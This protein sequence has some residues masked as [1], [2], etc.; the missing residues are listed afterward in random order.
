M[1]STYLK[2]IAGN[3][4]YHRKSVA[5]EMIDQTGCRHATKEKM[6]NII[7]DVAKQYS[8]IWKVRDDYIKNGIMQRDEYNGLIRML[9]DHNINP[10]TITDNLHLDG[11]TLKQGIKSAF[12]IFEDAFEEEMI[13]EG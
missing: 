5:L 8:T 12:S 10:V 1:I 3:G 2:I 13:K 6:K 9:H 4:D 7:R 11:K